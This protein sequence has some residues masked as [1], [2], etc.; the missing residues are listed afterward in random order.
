MKL[1][2]EFFEFILSVSSSNKETADV[3]LLPYGSKA[4]GVSSPFFPFKNM[5]TRNES[6]EAVLYKKGIL[7]KEW[8]RSL[9]LK[10]G[11]ESGFGKPT[12]KAIPLFAAASYV[13]F[14][15]LRKQIFPTKSRICKSI[16]RQRSTLLHSIDD[17]FTRQ[18]DVLGNTSCFLRSN[19]NQCLAIR[20]FKVFHL[21]YSGSEIS[22]PGYVLSTLWVVEIPILKFR[23]YYFTF[24]I[25]HSISQTKICIPRKFYPSY[26][27]FSLF[28]LPIFNFSQ[29]LIFRLFQVLKC[30][31]KFR[32]RKNNIH[33][34]QPLRD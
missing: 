5:S 34:H 23:K 17:E 7:P 24:L 8:K 13:F 6:A 12:V 9:V 25:H 2:D 3:L 28:V 30:S 4:S 22:L 19:K 29:M 16:Y 21:R 10:T 27:A 1:R 26:S 33:H 18:K 31:G 11:D 32:Y 20:I 14:S 15:Q